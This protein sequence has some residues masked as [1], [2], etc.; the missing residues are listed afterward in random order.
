MIV[1]VGE[2]AWYPSVVCMIIVSS[3]I[4]RKIMTGY[5]PVPES[6]S[7]TSKRDLRSSMA[8]IKLER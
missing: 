7:V 5:T 1:Y 6:K 8:G 2:G 4:H 3:Y